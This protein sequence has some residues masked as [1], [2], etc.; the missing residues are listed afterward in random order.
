[1]T[2]IAIIDQ[3]MLPGPRNE[4]AEKI[5]EAVD[6]LTAA[7]PPGHDRHQ[8][9]VALVGSAN[10]ITKDVDMRS[11]LICAFNAAT[12][13]LLPGKALGLCFFVP[14]KKMCNL[15]IGY[16]GY[17]DLAFRND[18]LVSCHAEAV[19]S[20]EQ[21]DFSYWVDSD[22]PQIH[23][24]PLLDRVVTRDNLIGAYCIYKTR[25]GGRG[26]R[27]L[28]KSQIDKSDSKQHVWNSNYY[29]MVRKTPIRIA[30]K[31]WKKTIT[32][33]NAVLLEE[34]ADQGIP[35]TILDPTIEIEPVKQFSLKDLKEPE[36]ASDRR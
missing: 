29:E 13:G 30:A 3:N 24:K 1:M 11:V 5:R 25:R 21:D 14:R 34:Q 9:A 22:G 15:E 32:L 19:I 18:H 10:D 20:D 33:A 8:F 16:Q 17:L 31:D 26:I 4:Y 12:I 28:N 27:W 7:L 2:Q 35:Q 6:R 36:D 23:H